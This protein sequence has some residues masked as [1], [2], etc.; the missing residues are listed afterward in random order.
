VGESIARPLLIAGS[1]KAEAAGAVHEMLTRVSLSSGYAGRY[2]DQLS[3]GERQRV[4]IARALVSRPAVLVCD[5]VTSALDVLVQ[6]AIVELL[7][8]LRRELGLAMLFVTHN[9]PLVRSI[10]QRVA[11][12]ADGRIVESGPTE[13]VLGNPQAEYTKKLL[14]D[15]PSVKVGEQ[16]G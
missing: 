15:T 16:A 14:A 12:M 3:G 4:A 6:A 13:E 10:A 9:L 11:V 7:A 8:E 2:P 1:S 5:E